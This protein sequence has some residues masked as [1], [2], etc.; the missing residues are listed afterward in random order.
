MKVHQNNRSV[1]VSPPPKY[2]SQ[3]PKSEQEEI[4]D[5]DIQK[6]LNQEGGFIDYFKL[7]FDKSRFSWK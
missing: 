5:E 3:I 6:A 1:G 7:S 4:S 2:L